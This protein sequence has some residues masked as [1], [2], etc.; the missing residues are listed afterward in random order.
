MTTLELGLHAHLS[1]FED[2]LSPVEQ[3][4]TDVAVTQA[5][6][7]LQDLQHVDPGPHGQRRV[8]AERMQP[9][10]EVVRGHGVVSAGGRDRGTSL[11]GG[12]GR[13]RDEQSDRGG[14]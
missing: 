6:V 3:E 13:E 4:E 12:A 10:Q 7:A 8:A 5:E 14:A 11:R 1:V 9:G 2:R